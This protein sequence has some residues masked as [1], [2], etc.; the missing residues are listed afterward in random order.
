MMIYNLLVKF[1]MWAR[2][3]SLWLKIEQLVNAIHMIHDFYYIYKNENACRHKLC[4]DVPNGNLIHNMKKI[5]WNM[6][7]GE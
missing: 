6:T 4:K 2:S 7:K 5:T 3:W 1:R